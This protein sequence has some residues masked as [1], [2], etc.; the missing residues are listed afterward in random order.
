MRNKVI[1]ATF[2]GL[3]AVGLALMSFMP[4]TNTKNLTTEK[5][6]MADDI[7]SYKLNSIDGKV[8]DF[9]KFKGKKLLIVNVASKCGYTPQYKKLQELH[10]KYGDKITIIGF[11]AN[12]FGGQEPG[13]NSEIKEFCSKNYGVSFQMMEK[14]SVKGDDAAPLYKYLSKAAGQEPKWNFCKYYIDEAGKT[15]KFF[16]SG[17]DP[18]SEDIVGLL[19]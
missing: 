6:I 14:I 17:T 16:S 2:L 9:S 3:A 8:I 10:S 5:K 11:P 15:V 12:N 19:K 18:L 1:M 13:S 4:T 7:Y